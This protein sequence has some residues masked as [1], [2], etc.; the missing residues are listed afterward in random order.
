VDQIEEAGRYFIPHVIEPSFGIDRI[1]YSVLE[2]AYSKRNKRTILRLPRDIASIKIAVFPL[3]NKDGL[4]ALTEK[5]YRLIVDEGLIAKYDESGSIG[6]RYARADEIGIPL[7]ITVDYQS[8]E[9]NT[10]TL[11]DISTWKQVRTKIAE[12]P[13][14]LHDYFRKKITFNEMGLRFNNL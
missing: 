7:C 14:L 12:L 11:R 13:E 5:V 6:R 3:V 8:L 10:V 4:P 2:Y 9:N 1:L